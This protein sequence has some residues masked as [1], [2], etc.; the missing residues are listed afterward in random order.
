[1][2]DGVISPELREDTFS[3]K[4]LKSYVIALAL[5]PLLLIVFLTANNLNYL[6]NKKSDLGKMQGSLRLIEAFTELSNEVS[7]EHFVRVAGVAQSVKIAQFERT[8]RTYSNLVDE[9]QRA[10]I[11]AETKS[12]YIDL[13]NHYL[14]KRRDTNTDEPID[15]ELITQIIST[16]RLLFS[17]LATSASFIGHQLDYQAFINTARYKENVFL[18]GTTLLDA[19]SDGKIDNK[20]YQ[21][22]TMIISAEAEDLQRI[23]ENSDKDFRRIFLETTS[24][25]AFE[26]SK[27]IHASLLS[28][29]YENEIVSELGYLGLIHHFKNYVLRGREYYHQESLKGYE[30]L[31]YNLAKYKEIIGDNEN[32]NIIDKTIDAYKDNL[33]VIHEQYKK[34]KSSR[35]IDKLVKIDDGPASEAIAKLKSGHLLTQTLPGWKQNW[36]DQMDLLH[37]LKIN[38]LHKVLDELNVEQREATTQIVAFIISLILVVV[39]TSIFAVSLYHKISRKIRADYESLSLAKREIEKKNLTLKQNLDTQ[40]D[41]NDLMNLM[42]KSNNSAQLANNVLTKVGSLLQDAVSVFY[43]INNERLIAKAAHGMTIGIVKDKAVG[44][45]LAGK[46]A[47]ESKVQHIHFVDESMHVDMFGSILSINYAMAIPIIYNG[48]VI[49]VLEFG[50]FMPPEDIEVQFI[51]EVA[52]LIA[53]QQLTLQRHE[54]VITHRSELELQKA[55]LEQ[56]NLSLE[57]NTKELL[58]QQSQLEKLNVELEASKRSL[59]LKAKELIKANKA[60]SMFLANVSHELRTPFNSIII[61]SKMLMRSKGKAMGDKEVKNASVINNAGEDLL[62]LINDILDLSKIEAGHITITNEEVSLR[63]IA[64]SLDDLFVVLAKEKGI[65]WSL[66]MAKDCPDIIVADKGKLEQILKNLIS[67]AI[68]FTSAGVVKLEIGIDSKSNISFTVTDSGVGIAKNKHEKVFEAFEQSDQS[69]SREY[70]GTGLGLTISKNLAQMMGGDLEL[71]ESVLG[72]GSKF[73][74]SLPSQKTKVLLSIGLDEEKRSK[75]QAV[76]STKGWM[77]TDASLHNLEYL[78]DGLLVTNF[79]YYHSVIAQGNHL[80]RIFVL[81]SSEEA[82]L[83][84]EKTLNN[85][86]VEIIIWTEASCERLLDHIEECFENKD[87]SAKYTNNSQIMGN[88]ALSALKGAEILVVDDDERNIYALTQVLEALEI[89]V[90]TARNGEECLNFLRTKNVDLVFMDIMMPVLDG[91]KTIEFIRHEMKDLKIPIIALTAKA[92]PEDRIQCMKVGASDY[93]SKPL[94]LDIVNNLL[95]KWIVNGAHASHQNIQ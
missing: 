31:K 15:T 66:E 35:E 22:L 72:E 81:T 51:A 7:K 79:E 52:P 73:R 89:T 91:Y 84:D 24:A 17:S 9:L 47:Q 23:L 77:I 60:K 94:N 27:I 87:S 38:P 10:D 34:G 70:G 12:H 18:E 16:P 56:A 28:K 42:M 75:L 43:I 2:K 6:I 95:I 57:E 71:V 8:Q 37:Q 53:T 65:S 49:S 48:Q 59:E 14:D 68:K 50:F 41:R 30:R 86:Q 33:K 3:F 76:I 54:E 83:I 45:G 88:E 46:A 55:E 93:V 90:F 36:R 44:E 40:K 25:P 63:S 92:M 13:L 21:T 1:M 64:S 74:L 29:L 61:L 85:A 69:I 26:V 82:Q 58:M 32:I 78:S 5:I 20:E 4:S 19:A 39:L 67:N 11:S 62:G 80:N